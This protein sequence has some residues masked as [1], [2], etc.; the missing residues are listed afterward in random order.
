MPLSRL[1]DVTAAFMNKG[2]IRPLKLTRKH[3]LFQD[4]SSKLGNEVDT[5]KTTQNG[6]ENLVCAL[7]GK[8]QME[9]VN[10]LR[11]TTFQPHP[12]PKK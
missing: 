5:E 6:L 9:S 7:Y 3:R 4:T 8:P 12:V 2:K 11:Y 10:S 1:S